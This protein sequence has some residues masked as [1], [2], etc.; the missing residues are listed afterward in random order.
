MQG[1]VHWGASKRFCA[2]SLWNAQVWIVVCNLISSPIDMYYFVFAPTL[3]YEL[4]F[5]RSPRIRVRFLMRRLF[6]MV[7]ETFGRWSP[8][9]T[10]QYRYSFPHPQPGICLILWW[11][12]VLKFCILPQLFFMQL[13]VGLIQQVWHSI[14]FVS[15]PVFK[16]IF[17]PL[18]AMAGNRL[19]SS[20]VSCSSLLSSKWSNTTDG[21]FSFVFIS[22]LQWMVPTIQNSM[23]PFQ[24]WICYLSVSSCFK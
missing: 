20:G 11:T 4:N 22:V 3:C 8:P 14:L 24:V 5:P 2:Q 18:I 13:L 6:E 12:W 21:G 15:W 19:S 17:Y 7:S 10:M 9:S 1:G 23:K 16:T